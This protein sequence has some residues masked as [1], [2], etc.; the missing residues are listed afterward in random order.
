MHGINKIAII[1]FLLASL[2]IIYKYIF[3]Y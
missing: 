2:Y 1:I 3:V